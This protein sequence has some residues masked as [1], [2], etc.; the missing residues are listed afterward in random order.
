[1]NGSVRFIIISSLP[2][3]VAERFDQARRRIQAVVRSRAA[4]AYPPHITLRTGLLVPLE[5][6]G[7]CVEDFGRIVGTWS[8]FPV[9]TDGFLLTSYR[10]G[11]TLKHLIGY[12]VR[13]D[14]ALAGLHERLL[15]YEPWRATDRLTF[16]P[17][18]T[19]A[20]DDLDSEGYRKARRWFD[21]DPDALP[22]GFQWM[23]DNVGLFRREGAQWTLFRDWRQHGRDGARSTN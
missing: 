22:G 16:E 3:E 11:Q 15:R 5:Q 21:E 9:R 17:H 8:P 6:V 7:S 14:A 12:R 4:L 10:D 2:R 13:K 18:L 20:F 19:L 23:C 1:M